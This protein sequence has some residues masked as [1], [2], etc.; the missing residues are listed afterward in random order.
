VT[1]FGSQRAKKVS[2]KAA[3]PSRLESNKSNYKIFA[4]SFNEI[5]DHLGGNQLFG[6]SLAKNQAD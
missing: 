3:R 5:I 1:K 6:T 2:S 4:N